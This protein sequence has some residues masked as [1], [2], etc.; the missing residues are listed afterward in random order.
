MTAGFASVFVDEL[1]CRNVVDFRQ[2]GQVRL[3]IYTKVHVVLTR[4]YAWG[5][6][7]KNVFQLTAVA[8]QGFF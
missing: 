1:D 3:E 2:L 6:T 8:S 5:M 7:T 4:G